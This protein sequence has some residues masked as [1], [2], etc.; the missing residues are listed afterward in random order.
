MPIRIMHVIDHLGKGG[1]ENGL[2][3]LING[4]DPGRFEH[5]VYAIRRLGPNADRLPKHRVRIICQGK[6]DTD[7]RFQILKLARG[8]REVKP[9]VVHS[10]NWASIEA[11]IAARLVGC[12]SV[13]HSE[14]GLE[15]AASVKEPRRRIW[16]RRVA[17]EL[18]HRVLSVSHQLKD[19]HAGRT[20][21][22]PDRITVLHNGVD[23]RR[24]FPDPAARARARRELNLSENDFCIGC[25]GNLLP[26]KDHMTVLRAVERLDGAWR[27]VITGEGPER[28]RLERFLDTRP[29]CKRRVS[30]VG[31]SDR[32]PDMLNAMDVY[33]LS[34]TAEGICNS[35]LEA[36]STALPALATGTGGN[37]EV[38]VDGESGILFP[39]GD[40]ARLATELNRL[41]AHPEIRRELGRQAV[42]RVRDEFSIEAMIRKYDE[43]YES[44]GRRLAP[45]V[46]VVAR[47]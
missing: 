10:R 26:V 12:C 15:T 2:V 45:A 35:L 3:N 44:L 43:L 41:R 38:V 29:E 25:V 1:L 7:S 34:S 27:L 36:M 47:A 20:G 22:K 6:Q 31:S 4:L 39:V 37:P 21:F 33:V 23:A 19:L 46:G 24:F 5:T 28:S 17:Y 11:V 30:L 14:H 32:V 13:V 40:F 42:R 8:I 18:A 9:D 16:F